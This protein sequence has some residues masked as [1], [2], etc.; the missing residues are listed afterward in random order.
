MSADRLYGS[1]MTT[2]SAPARPDGRHDFDFL[3]GRWH[4][5]QRKL[6][7]WLAGCEEWDE[8]PADLH[9]QPVIGGLGNFDELASPAMRY[10][11]LALRLYDDATQDWSIYWVVGGVAELAPP[12][13]GHFADG[14]GDF[15]GPDTHEGTPVLV[16]YRW[17]DIT[18]TTASW[19][20]A[21]STDDGATW[22]T[23]WTA[24][25]TRAETAAT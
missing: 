19:A 17:S 13:V 12:V 21:F 9:C 3:H 5:R 24:Q 20:Q 6:R 11:G 18:E 2:E 16:R 10:T 1:G 25:F 14:V 22:E 4:T 23:N 15:F 7:K 8:F